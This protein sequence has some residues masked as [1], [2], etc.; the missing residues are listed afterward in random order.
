MSRILFCVEQ[1]IYLEGGAVLVEYLGHCPPF[2][3]FTRAYKKPLRHPTSTQK[4][5]WSP[6]FQGQRVSEG[7]ASHTFRMNKCMTQS[8][9]Y[10]RPYNKTQQFPAHRAVFPITW[11]WRGIPEALKPLTCRLT[12]MTA[13]WRLSYLNLTL[14]SWLYETFLLKFRDFLF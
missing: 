7:A 10:V 9:I 3:V 11:L 1:N 13:G 5:V 4:H 8:V 12:A 6:T 2:E 14:S